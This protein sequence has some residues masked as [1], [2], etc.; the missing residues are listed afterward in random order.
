M[1]MR[2]VI[3]PL[4]DTPEQQRGADLQIRA[5][6]QSEELMREVAI[7]GVGAHATGQFP[8]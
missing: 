1:A 2:L 8:R 4:A 7:I 3:E 5:G 6:H